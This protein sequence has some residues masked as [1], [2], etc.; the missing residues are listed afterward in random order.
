MN[1][2][3]IVQIGTAKELLFTPANDFVANFI[4]GQQFQ[5]E[6]EN[7]TLKD[8]WQ[9]LPKAIDGTEER[10]LLPE[11]SLWQAIETI[12]ATGI[13]SSQRFVSEMK[14]DKKQVDVASLMAGYTQFKN[15]VKHE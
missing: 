13:S 7:L 11:D 10:S 6:L 12:S 4:K 14:N 1:K 3:K 2:G 5:L 8:V 9:F 15:L